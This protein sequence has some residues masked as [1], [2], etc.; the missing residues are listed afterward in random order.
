MT[1]LVLFLSQTLSPSVSP[2]SIAQGSTTTL[3]VTFDGAGTTVVALQWG[4]ALPAGVTAVWSAG[5]A[6]TAAG[7]S[8]QCNANFSVCL[9]Y[10]LN[11]TVI[12]PGVV[13]TAVLTPSL[14]GQDA[15]VL[16]AALG[17]DAM[18]NAVTVAGAP[19]LLVVIPDLSPPTAPSAGPQ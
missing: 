5:P 14:A 16:D 3:N 7:K 2:A 4:L 15:L 6:A 19:T 18:G 17:S 11:S 12:G 9:A 10:G 13:A 8:V 1:W